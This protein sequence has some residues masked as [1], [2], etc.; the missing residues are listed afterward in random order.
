MNCD[1]LSVPHWTRGSNFLDL[2]RRKKV[3][4]H[5]GQRNMDKICKASEKGI[6]WMWDVSFWVITGVKSLEIT[7]VNSISR[8]TAV[9]AEDPKWNTR[10]SSWRCWKARQWNT[11]QRTRTKETGIKTFLYDTKVQRKQRAWLLPVC[12]GKLIK[13]VSAA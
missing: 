6:I 7:R 12:N 5:L 13:W 11:D 1:I 4:S 9:N 2:S 3:S 8:W 10:F